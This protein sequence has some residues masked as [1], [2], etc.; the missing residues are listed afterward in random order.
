[1][2]FFSV[3]FLGGAYHY[4]SNL[5]APEV[6]FGTVSLTQKQMYGY[7]VVISIPLLWFSSAGSAVFW[8]IGAS[9]IIILSHAALLEPPVERA[10]EDNV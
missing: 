2:L 5:Q 4:I 10:F 9:A 6:R 8:I 3:A 1:M 7:L